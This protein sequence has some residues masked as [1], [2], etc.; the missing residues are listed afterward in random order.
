MTL[1]VEEIATIRTKKLIYHTSMFN[2]PTS[3][4]TFTTEPSLNIPL[5]GKIKNLTKRE[6][7]TVTNSVDLFASVSCKFK[8]SPV[9]MPHDSSVCETLIRARSFMLLSLLKCER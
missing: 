4:F 1:K 3:A 2:F 5:L 8:Y 7:Y 9:I 6:V